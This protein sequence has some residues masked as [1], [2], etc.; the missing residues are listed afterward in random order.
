MTKKTAEP[1]YYL[2]IDLEIVQLYAQRQMQGPVGFHIQR[3]AA[4]IDE[5]SPEFQQ[6]AEE[7]SRSYQAI[8]EKHPELAADLQGGS[9]E[10]A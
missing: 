8:L 7:I 3:L 4:I 5:D 2:P 9:D 6:A 1:D 10:R